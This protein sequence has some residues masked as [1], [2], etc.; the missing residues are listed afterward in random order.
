MSV[1]YSIFILQSHT[2]FNENVTDVKELMKSGPTCSRLKFKHLLEVK[3]LKNLSVQTA[4]G[5][6][7]VRNSVCY[8]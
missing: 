8:A 1:M 6:I 7:K 2:V 3:P 5:E 4:V